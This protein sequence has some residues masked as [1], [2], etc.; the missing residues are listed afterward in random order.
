MVLQVSSPKIQEQIL[1]ILPNSS[2][3]QKKRK[4]YLNL[5]YKF[6]IIQFLKN[7]KKYPTHENRGKNS[8]KNW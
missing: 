5:F 6:S 8:K 4:Y 1:S 7:K 3:K 2:R